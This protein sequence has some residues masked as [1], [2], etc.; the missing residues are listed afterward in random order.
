M[1]IRGV[2]HVSVPSDDIRSQGV[3]APP[4]SPEELEAATA[5]HRE[6]KRP[7]TYRYGF[8][9]VIDVPLPLL[10]QYI[11]DLPLEDQQEFLNALLEHLPANSLHKLDEDIRMRMSRG[12][13]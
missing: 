9:N 10:A 12:G 6:K 8:W 7:P 1:R 5:R 2:N 4:N 11:T 3:A 13:A